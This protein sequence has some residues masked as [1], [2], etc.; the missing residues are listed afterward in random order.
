MSF[1]SHSEIMLPAIEERLRSILTKTD[2]EPLSGLH[3]ML[4]YHLGFEG[5]GAGRQARG[6]RI[7]P[8]ILLLTTEA[9][10]GKWRDALS[11]A[12]SVELI[13]NFS[14]IHDDIEDNSPKRRGRPTVWKKWGIA[15]AINT[16]DAM[17]T[18]AFIVLHDLIDTVSP[19]ITLQAIQILHETCLKLTQG[20]YLD[21]SYERRGDLTIEAYWPMVSGKTAALLAACTEMGALIADID[22]D[23]RQ[24]YKKFGHSLG[25]AFQAKDDLLGVWGD[26]A[27]TGKSTESD[28]ITGKKTLPILYGLGLDGPFARRWQTGNISPDEVESLADQLA[29]EGVLDYTQSLSDQLT[30]SALA[31]LESAQPA[32]DTGD[33]L[34]EL[35]NLLL[36]RQH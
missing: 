15:Q 11:A 35:A 28:L 26:A 3:Y 24:K 32:G 13:H 6:K 16:G 29:A 9:A 34:V 36:D 4:A 33:S 23:L 14:L 17:F 19:T 20:Q 12:A 1:Q 31:A 18:L 7:R 22:E 10:G 5:D 21:I 27:L 25:L 2:E 8:L 30:Q